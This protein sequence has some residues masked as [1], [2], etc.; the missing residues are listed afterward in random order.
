MEVKL[1]LRKRRWF[2]PKDGHYPPSD[3]LVLGRWKTSFLDWWN[4]ISRVHFVYYNHR[5]E[6][7]YHGEDGFDIDEPTGSPLW[8]V[9][10]ISR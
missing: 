7:W 10:V 6:S 1:E 5:S 8:G 9:A 3:T 2:C 4:G